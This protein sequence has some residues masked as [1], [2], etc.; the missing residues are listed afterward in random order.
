MRSPNWIPPLL[1]AFA[2]GAL[3]LAGA[4]PASGSPE[5]SGECHGKRVTMHGTDG[6]DVVKTADVSPGDVLALGDGDDYVYL[7]HVNDITICG[8]Q[9][10]DNLI[11]GLGA[12][13]GLLLD[14]EDG[15]DD[16]GSAF[17]DNGSR[18]VAHHSLILYGGDA[19]DSLAGSLEGD[20]IHGGS[21]YDLVG[22]NT[23][24][25]RIWGDGA[26]DQLAGEGGADRM[27]G[28][29]GDDNVRGGAYLS[30]GPKFDRGDFTD[31]GQGRDYC[32]GQKKRS[33]EKREPY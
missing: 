18:K 2:T 30:P 11:A 3:L 4:L 7:R 23:G 31:G 28:G 10:D 9:G 22:G 27:W 8:G 15:R 13:R 33:C 17:Y 16:V 26:H 25:D 21:G 1:A 5:R 19:S 12:G 24:N 14:G 29:R 6:D 20:R 32:A